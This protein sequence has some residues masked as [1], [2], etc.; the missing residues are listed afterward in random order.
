RL[1]W[2]AWVE[3]RDK[4]N[5]NWPYKN[6]FLDSLLPYFSWISE[7]LLAKYGLNFYQSAAYLANQIRK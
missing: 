1:T 2:P 6:L 3:S 5:I 4:I 7:S